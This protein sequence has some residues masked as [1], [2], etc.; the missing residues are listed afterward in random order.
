LDLSQVAPTLH[1]DVGGYSALL[2]KEVLDRLELPAFDEIPG[3]EEE[4]DRWTIPQT[5]IVIVRMEEGEH[6][7]Q[8]FF[9]AQS[10]DRLQEF[11]DRVRDL[12]YAPDASAGLLDIYLDNPGGLVPI[13]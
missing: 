6:V 3:A 11:Y 13:N 1:L 12:P 2:L 8:Y 4:L 7:D 5:E 9:S 10:V